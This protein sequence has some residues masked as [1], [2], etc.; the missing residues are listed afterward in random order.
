M[1]QDCDEVEVGRIGLH[2]I[3]ADGE[4]LDIIIFLF[5][6]CANQATC[7]GSWL[8][9]GETVPQTTKTARFCSTKRF[10]ELAGLFYFP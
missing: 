4:I 10:V 1:A 5:A 9:R 3:I 7:H 2:D 6:A 8:A